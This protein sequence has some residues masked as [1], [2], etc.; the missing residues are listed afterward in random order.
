M[1]EVAVG[2]VGVVL[3][4]VVEVME[5]VAV[6]VGNEAG[7]DVDVQVDWNLQVAGVV[8]VATQIDVVVDAETHP[9]LGVVSKVR[10]ADH[11]DIG[12]VVVVVDVLNTAN[13]DDLV[14][15]EVDAFEVPVVL[16]CLAVMVGQVAD[17]ELDD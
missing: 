14:G 2:V 12:V 17:V 7:P 11:F 15:I 9:E 10:G 6:V 16:V 13:W 4:V 5:E 3:E 1:A 8:V